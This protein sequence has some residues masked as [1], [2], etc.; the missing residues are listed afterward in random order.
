MIRGDCNVRIMSHI[1]RPQ[2]LLTWVAE[3]ELCA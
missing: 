3:R 2:G 1:A